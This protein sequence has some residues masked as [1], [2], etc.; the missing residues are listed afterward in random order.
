[1]SRARGG[2][3]RHAPDPIRLAL[4]Y[5]DALHQ[6]DAERMAGFLHADT[7]TEFHA[8]ICTFL[9]DEADEGPDAD[10]E[11][12]VRAKLAGDGLTL[13]EALAVSPLRMWS[14]VLAPVISAGAFLDPPEILG[15]VPEG[16]QIIHVLTRISCSAGEYRET[17]L[18][19]LSFWYD[20]RDWWLDAGKK[21]HGLASALR[22][23]RRSTRS[24]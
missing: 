19:V 24:H 6:G 16:D 1:M 3:P 8:L 11:Y 9:R 7:L 5:F 2:K 14:R 10:G 15:E 4:A 22:N 13:E 17:A 12:A 18:E 20:G 21:I 23:R